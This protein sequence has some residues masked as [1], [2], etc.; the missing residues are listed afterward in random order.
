MGGPFHRPGP[1]ITLKLKPDMKNVSRRA[2]W[3][4]QDSNL[5]VTSFSP[6]GYR[7]TALEFQWLFH[8]IQDHPVCVSFHACQP[9]PAIGQFLLSRN[10]FS[11]F[12]KV[13]HTP[14]RSGSQQIHIACIASTIRSATDAP[15]PGTLWNPGRHPYPPGFGLEYYIITPGTFTPRLSFQ[16]Q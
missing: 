16:A 12:V 8:H 2:L 5:L 10:P 15:S 3:D 7:V 11:V 6:K 9:M 4:G 14:R 1:L 13:S